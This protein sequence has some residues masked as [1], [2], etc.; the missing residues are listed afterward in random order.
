MTVVEQLAG[1]W[2]EGTLPPVV[3]RAF[4]LPVALAAAC[5]VALAGCGGDDEGAGDAQQQARAVVE[6]FGTA[7]A[8]RDYRTICDELLADSLVKKVEDI[9]LPCETAFERGVGGVRDPRIEVREVKVQ[10]ARALVSVRSTAAGEDPSDDAVELA[11]EDGEWRIV[12]LVS[13]G[14]SATTTTTTGTTTTGS[15]SR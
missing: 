2:A 8:Q 14:G 1:H 12:S 4:G 6:R 10:G 13:P 5:A 3:A 11:R 9:G 7:T 15:S